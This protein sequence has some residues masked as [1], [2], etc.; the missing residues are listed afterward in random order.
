M[1][2]FSMDLAVSHPALRMDSR[3]GAGDKIRSAGFPMGVVR[4]AWPFLVKT[5]RKTEPVGTGKKDTHSGF[6]S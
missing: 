5:Q 4:S 2:Q 1:N 6:V 3:L